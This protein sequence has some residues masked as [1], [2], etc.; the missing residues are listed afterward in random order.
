M[1]LSAV[2]VTSNRDAWETGK[3]LY[4]FLNVVQASVYLGM[5]VICYGV[6]RGGMEMEKPAR[7][8]G[9]YWQKNWDKNDW[10][11]KGEETTC[12]VPIHVKM[13]C[14]S[15]DETCDHRGF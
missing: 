9:K 11:I 1:F 13:V 3:Y 8:L 12:I 7:P 2:E 15:L 10:V 4:F 14:S 5:N 6:N